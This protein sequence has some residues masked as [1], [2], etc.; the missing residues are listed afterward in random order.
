MKQ[1]TTWNATT[2]LEENCSE[3]RLHEWIATVRPRISLSLSLSLSLSRVL[4]RTDWVAAVQADV[5]LLRGDMQAE[6][7]MEVKGQ[8]PRKCA[9]RGIPSVSQFLP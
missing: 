1:V 7:R 2:R 6:R 5:S 4:A 9:Q 8:D 3:T